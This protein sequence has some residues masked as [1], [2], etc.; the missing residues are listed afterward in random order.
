M[1]LTDF[2]N[3]QEKNSEFIG[4]EVFFKLHDKNRKKGR[5]VG[6]GDDIWSPKEQR[7]A[8][9]DLNQVRA[10]VSTDGPP[11]PVGQSIPVHCFP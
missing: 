4:V 3:V 9:R 10:S 7:M 5:H 1:I 11:R 8:R 6:T 2:L